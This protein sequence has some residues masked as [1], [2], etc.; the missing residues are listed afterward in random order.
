MMFDKVSDELC[1]NGLTALE[2]HEGWLLSGT[3]SHETEL[4]HVAVSSSVTSGR[5][6]GEVRAVGWLA[7]G[8][9]MFRPGVQS[10]NLVSSLRV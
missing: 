10:G 8:P 2:C 6:A 9:G 7:A 4:H 3:E 1:R 5:T